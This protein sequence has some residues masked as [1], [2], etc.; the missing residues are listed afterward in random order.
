MKMLSGKTLANVV[1]LVLLSKSPFLNFISGLKICVN[2]N[3]LYLIKKLG[4]DLK[5]CEAVY[6]RG[7]RRPR[8]SK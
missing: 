7:R 1:R 2:K 4:K 5:R 8:G 6:V 3:A